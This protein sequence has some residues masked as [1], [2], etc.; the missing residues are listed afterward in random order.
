MET[1]DLKSDGEKS[2][3]W[4]VK[5][6]RITE[7]L[8]FSFDD[9]SQDESN[10]LLS[11]AKF[12][13]SNCANP[14]K[15]NSNN[16][17]IAM[18][19]V[20]SGKTRSFTTVLALAADNGY[21]LAIV[22]A[23]TK[24]NLLTQTTD[25]LLTD[26]EING[27]NSERLILETDPSESEIKR[28]LRITSSPL[29]IIP[30]LKNHIHLKRIARI[31]ESEEV[32]KYLKNMPALII[33]DEA[34]Q[35]SLNTF[36]RQNDK[37][38]WEDDKFSST[39]SAIIKL[40][41]NL[42]NHTYLQYTATPQGPLL[43]S[44]TDMLSPSFHKVLS[45][46]KTYTGGKTFFQDRTELITRIPENE[47]Y[48]KKENPLLQCPK[49]LRESLQFFIL[50]S[51]IHIKF[52]KNKNPFTMMIHPD[53]EKNDCDLFYSWVKKMI[54]KW[55]DKLDL[56]LEDP[57]YSILISEFEKNYEKYKNTIKLAPEFKDII[58]YIFDTL[59]ITSKWLVIGE[60][61]TKFPEAKP[62][63]DWSKS[64]NHIVVGADMLNRG[65]TVEG[66]AI[67]YMPRYS[68]SMSISDT[69]QQR[70]R[71]FGYKN[72]YIDLCRIYLPL[73]SINE[74]TAYVEDEEYLRE[75]LKEHSLKEL[76]QTLLHTD[77]MNPT[78]NNIL[79]KRLIKNKMEG[80]RGFHS[81][82]INNILDNK[83]LYKSILKKHDFEL[84]IDY[85]TVLRN[86]GF[87][88]ISIED[89]LG[90]LY[91]FKVS[92]P[93]EMVRKSATLQYLRLLQSSNI[94]HCY[95][96]KMDLEADNEQIRKRTILN[97]DETLRCQQLFS[98]RS[99]KGIK[100]YPGDAKIGYPD[101][102]TIQLYNI[103]LKP[104]KDNQ[105]TKFNNLI[106][107]TIALVYPENIKNTFVGLK[108]E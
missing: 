104:P 98:G 9:M 5:P 57:E 108:D 68:K 75:F 3:T 81:L 44:L 7:R 26:L 50:G 67:T 46:G 71:Y 86:H 48:N 38:E 76:A 29:I 28:A 63:V 31:F 91:K 34:D 85:G 99:T 8:L 35:A 19:Y 61:K 62:K 94:N 92:S 27:D 59:L 36:A 32:S 20:Q 102:L 11:E 42:P 30:I 51:I 10:Q 69:I 66:L 49:S 2:K 82:S 40:K 43:I 60:N 1:V 25:R 74:Y 97:S 18:G 45:P 84:Y 41:N 14:E 37:K 4:I 24:N 89:G 106:F 64:K 16:T 80:A 23:G 6:G 56:K 78:R 65:F 22:F 52:R 73:D 87:V 55:T 107:N 47:V 33:D 21:R 79:S 53:R 12:L 88:K 17:G 54:E 39:Y 13:L 100:N 77:L 83:Q 58:P 105:K 70:A 72:K 101:S 95:L 93:F 90:I 103:K 96:F 15:N